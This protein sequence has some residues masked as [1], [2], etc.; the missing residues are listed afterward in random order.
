MHPK[1]K[2]A[3]AVRK[4]NYKML[5][6][7]MNN[8]TFTCDTQSSAHGKHHKFGKYLLIGAIISS[9]TLFM[10]RNFDKTV[11][12][13]SAGTDMLGAAADAPGEFGGKWNLWE[14]IGD[15]VASLIGA[16]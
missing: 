4:V 12:P 13:V 7:Q 3:S 2:T 11:I 14:Y 10:C 15:T 16:Q 9:V 1:E 5:F 6:Q 8:D